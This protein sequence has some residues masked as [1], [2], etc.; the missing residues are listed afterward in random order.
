M[1]ITEN[2]QH[3]LSFNVSVHVYR[4]LLL[5][6]LSLP[7]FCDHFCSVQFFS[8]CDHLLNFLTHLFFCVKLL[9]PVWSPFKKYVVCIKT[10][11]QNHDTCLLC[12][13]D[14]YCRIQVQNYLKRVQ[15]QR[16]CRKVRNKIILQANNILYFFF[17]RDFHSTFHPN[18]RNGS[19]QTLQCFYSKYFNAFNF[20]RSSIFCLL[21]AH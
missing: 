10:I 14:F 7:A 20:C 21:L 1:H 15:Y 2:D 6:T 18:F 19:L 12:N 4:N 11:L 9:A 13:L 17:V 5:F 3:C 8:C 16:L